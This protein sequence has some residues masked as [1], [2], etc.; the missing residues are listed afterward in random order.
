MAVL[1][2]VPAL[3]AAPVAA[4]KAQEKTRDTIKE[5]ARGLAKEARENMESDGKTYSGKVKGATDVM[6]L[7]CE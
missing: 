4:L 5:I 2:L 6:S 1:R 3:S 7:L